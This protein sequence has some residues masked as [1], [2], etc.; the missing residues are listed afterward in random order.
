MSS[1][2]T[3]APR[4]DIALDGKWIFLRD[5]NN[6]GKYKGWSKKLPEG[7]P[8]EVGRPWEY[9]FP[10]YDGVGWY[11]REFTLPKEWSDSRVVLQFDAVSYYCE[12]W[13]NGTLLGSHEGG[14]MPFEFDLAAHCRF[15]ETNVLTV[16]VINAPM[17]REI[18]GFRS[19]A[20]LSQSDIPTGKSG[21][22]YN[23]GGIWQD[24]RVKRVPKLSVQQV[25]V[26]PNLQKQVLE[27]DVV[28]SNTGD[29]AAASIHLS[30][31][32]ADGAEVPADVEL[33]VTAAK[34]V[35]IHRA[36]VSAQGLKKWTPDS[37]TLYRAKVRLA[38]P[39]GVDQVEQIFGYREF[40][41]KGER[42]LL[43]GEPVF[44]KGFLQQGC[45]PRTLAIPETRELAWQELT[46]VKK[47]GFNFIR[48]HMK[49]APTW[50]LDMADKLGLLIM[51]EPPIGWIANGPKTRERCLREMRDLV[52]RDINHPCVVIIGLFNESFHL[53]GFIPEQILELTTEMSLE[54][55]K[56]DP[57]RLF[58][59]TSGGFSRKVLAGPDTMIH[60]SGAE[61]FMISRA[62]LPWENEFVEIIDLHKY[63]AFPATTDVI[64]SYH[65]VSAPGQILFIAEFGA[66]ET[67]PD[68]ESVLKEFRPEEADRRLEDWQLH[69]DFL[70]SLNGHFAKSGLA[71]SLANSGEFIKQVNQFSVDENRTIAHVIRTNPNVSG[72]CFCQLADASGELFGVT[73]IW[74]RPKP[75][76]NALSSA[77]A[78]PSIGVR[79]TTRT[80]REGETLKFHVTL[81]AD[82]G[83]T[84]SGEAE[85][86]VATRSGSSVWSEKKKIGA[87]TAAIDVWKTGLE[88]K[89]VPGD[90]T[91]RAHFVGQDGK[92]NEHTMLFH[93]LAAPKLTPRKVLLRDVN[94]KLEGFLRSSK[95]EIEAYGNNTRD[96]NTPV[97][98]N[99]EPIPSNR[100]F[101]GELYGQ[102]KK[103][104]SLGGC[105]ILFD[106][107]V[108]ALYKW[109]FPTYLR[110]QPVMRT[111]GYTVKHPVFAGLREPGVA[112]YYY[113]DIFPQKWDSSED[114]VAA[115]G[116]VLFGTFS[117][118]MWTRPAVYFWGAALYRVPIAR[119]NV[120][121]CH[122]PLANKLDS[123]PVAGQLL[124]NLVN[125][126]SSLIQ[127]GGENYLLARCIDPLP[128]EALRI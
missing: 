66:P 49:P 120:I 77:V 84:Y 1:P 76:Y 48:N 4:Q 38:G 107:E 79:L 31:S 3:L 68:F 126:A 7:T 14:F 70:D 8:I 11:E 90:Y 62:M 57:S 82:P 9:W 110:P 81:V 101:Y 28:L 18:E 128:E 88:K 96:K 75:L 123:S 21:W 55:R 94:G 112:D 95:W 124:D 45:W 89:L 117:M 69:R 73:D 39:T 118:N 97:L 50:Y 113:G 109:L 32:E 25:R 119:G 60:D 5:E 92:T 99:V 29:A 64:E 106:P 51:H 121:V 23:F 125:Y 86:T 108:H 30:V 58:I 103:I 42:Y 20:P 6:A 65:E 19:G 24:V 33:K 2:A 52:T 122:L 13:L 115:G 78:D 46:D 102:L 36:Q 61:G 56:I 80:L 34:G 43:N 127:K 74:R 67:P 116:E 12:C 15:G 100:A 26:F 27:V 44:L 104:V 114:I 105:A 59:D 53:F 17:D 63:C 85:V 41:Q 111:C 37:P 54:A 47:R 72:M 35:S 83:V 10:R 71:Q 22:Y 93:V 40:T 91:I 16:R 87:N 98:L